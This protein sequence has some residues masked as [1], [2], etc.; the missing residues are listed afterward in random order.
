MQE[1]FTPLERRGRHGE[2]GPSSQ[3]H[4]ARMKEA[5]DWFPPLYDHIEEAKRFLRSEPFYDPDTY[6][7]SLILIDRWLA[8]VSTLY[9]P[10][11]I[12]VVDNQ[13]RYSIYSS[14]D[15]LKAVS[16]EQEN[17][18]LEVFRSRLVPDILAQAPDLV[19][20]SITATSQIMPG[21]TLCRLLKQAHPDLHLTI[22]GS[23][24]TRPGD[25]LPR[26]GAEF[27]VSGDVL[28]FEGETA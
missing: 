18:Y 9:F 10:T 6:R 21:L 3:E 14:K 12:S 27:P 8:F 4:L 24:F 20:V 17:P 1:K 23:N 26:G 5:L 2:T 7:E 16:D 19:G 22:G 28:V 13:W 15:I 11:R 25:K